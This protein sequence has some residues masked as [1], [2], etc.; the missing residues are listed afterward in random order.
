MTRSC[1]SHSPGSF[2]SGGVAA[3]N[4][5]SCRSGSELEQGSESESVSESESESDS[6]SESVV[7]SQ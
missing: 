1:R 7:S 6:E 3:V 2:H 5:F 4:Q